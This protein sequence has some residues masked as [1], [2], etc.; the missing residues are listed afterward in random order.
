MNKTV[1]IDRDGVIVE[2]NNYNKIEQLKLIEGSAKAIK[3]LNK[4]N[5]LT[6]I[7][8]NQAGVAKNYFTEND[9]I[10]FNNKL[11]EKLKEHNNCHI[12]AIY[13]CPH[14]PNSNCECRKPKSGML[15]TAK[16]KFDIDFTESFMIG[17]KITDIEAGDNVGCKTIMVMTG[18]GKENVN[19]KTNKSYHVA[20]NLYDAV[21]FIIKEII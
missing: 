12:D 18:Y 21:K 16:G 1:F 4:N 7:I 5:F 15:Y 13:Y 14:H 19:I 6:I 3:L 11:K 20:E 9:V 17:D 2:E 10:I 8:T